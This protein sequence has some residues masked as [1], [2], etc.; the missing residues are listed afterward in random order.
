MRFSLGFA[1]ELVFE[2]RKIRHA[3]SGVSPETNHLC[4]WPN[5]EMLGNMPKLPR[6]VLVNNKGTLAHARFAPRSLGLPTKEHARHKIISDR[7]CSDFTR[8]H[9]T[10]AL[11]RFVL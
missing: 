11:S 10:Q 9:L 4:F 6:K 8:I 3:K 5:G 7:L 2:P 1:V